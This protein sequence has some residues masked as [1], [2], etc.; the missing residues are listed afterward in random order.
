[1]FRDQEILDAIQELS[2]SIMLIK[3]FPMGD[4]WHKLADL[5]ELCQSF[6]ANLEDTLLSEDKIKQL[7]K[8]AIT[9]YNAP[10][11]LRPIKKRNKNK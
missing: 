7:V 4:I 3:S 5:E 10:K 2:H 1:M 8:D 6:K 9:E 11:Q